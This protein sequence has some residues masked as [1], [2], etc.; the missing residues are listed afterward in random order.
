[1]PQF[2]TALLWA[3]AA[4]FARGVLAAQ[5]SKPLPTRATQGASL[6]AAVQVTAGYDPS[7][8]PVVQDAL[9][10]RRSADAA[11][12][13]LLLAPPP[14]GAGRPG[15]WGQCGPNACATRPRL[16]FSPPPEGTQGAKYSGIA[17]MRLAVTAEGKPENI[18][19]VKSLGHELDKKAIEAVRKWKFEPA[20]KDGK[21]V[22]VEI[23]VEVNFNLY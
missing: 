21:P 6:Q 22:A 16:T 19:V 13:G 4:L 5:D 18:K 9:K 11:M 10:L 17:I 1:M 2:R 23:A 8:D 3:A 12:L 14:A 7:K 15:G 20:M